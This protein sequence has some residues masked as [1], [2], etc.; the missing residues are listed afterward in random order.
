[1]FNDQSDFIVVKQALSVL[2]F[3]DDECQV[4]QLPWCTVI[5]VTTVAIEL[6]G[7]SEWCYSP[8]QPHLC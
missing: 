4:Y 3:R 6:M 8:W 5:T 7:Y 1:M 2:G